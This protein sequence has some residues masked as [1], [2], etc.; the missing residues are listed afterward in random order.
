MPTDSLLQCTSGHLIPELDTLEKDQTSVKGTNKQQTVPTYGLV[1]VNEDP[2]YHFSLGTLIWYGLFFHVDSHHIV[3]AR[4]FVFLFAVWMLQELAALQVF[5]YYPYLYQHTWLARW[6]SSLTF[7]LYPPT[8]ALE[9]EEQ[10]HTVLVIHLIAVPLALAL[11]QFLLLSPLLSSGSSIAEALYWEEH[12]TALG[13]YVGIDQVDNVYDFNL[14]FEVRLQRN[15]HAR[16]SCFTKIKC[17]GYLFKYSVFPINMDSEDAKQSCLLFAM[18]CLIKAFIILIIWPFYILPCFTVFHVFYSRENKHSQNDNCGIRRVLKQLIIPLGIIGLFFMFLPFLFFYICFMIFLIVD[19]IR[20][21][22][23]TLTAAIFIMSIAANV[24]SAFSGLEDDYRTVKSALFSVMEELSESEDEQE[25][26]VSSSLIWKGEEGELAVPRPLFDHL[27]SRYLPLKSQVSAVLLGLLK[28][29]I[30][31]G[32]LYAIIKDYQIFDQFSETG[33]SIITV[34]FVSLP[35][36][37]GSE[38]TEAQSELE[39]RERLL[40]VKAI[41]LGIFESEDFWAD[42]KPRKEGSSTVADMTESYVT[43]V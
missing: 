35:S 34:V 43:S 30:F 33:E 39:S 28:N 19:V 26:E 38:K 14:P 41:I 16:L 2:V 12:D 31:F 27:C 10:Y 24:R 8:A 11:I 9:T 1:F 4:R 32:L 25:K 21:I 42:M 6:P 29:L 3:V 5:L 13:R 37:L 20:N 18:K 7:A 23:D 36:L 22:S 17:W 15:L 40:K